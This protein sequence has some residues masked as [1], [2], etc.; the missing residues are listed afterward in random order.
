MLRFVVLVNSLSLFCLTPC[1]VTLFTCLVKLL[2]S[3]TV[4][5]E[6]NRNKTIAIPVP[7]NQKFET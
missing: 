5:G 3:L 4:Q 2:A 7:A 1:P 6:I